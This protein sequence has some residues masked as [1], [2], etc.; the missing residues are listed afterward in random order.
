MYMKE[1]RH[2]IDINEVDY[3]ILEKISVAKVI[4]IL[5]EKNS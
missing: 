3:K 4:H 5:L 2:Q 1:H